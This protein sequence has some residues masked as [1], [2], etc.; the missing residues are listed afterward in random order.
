V[1]EIVEVL[2]RALHG[3]DRIA[4]ALAGYDIAHQR[5]KQLGLPFRIAPFFANRFLIVSPDGRW[6]LATHMD[7]WDRDIFVLD[8]YR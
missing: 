2:A 6:L 1:V 7:R 4:R 8:N 3:G 5:V